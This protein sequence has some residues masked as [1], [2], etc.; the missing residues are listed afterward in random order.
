MDLRRRR[1]EWSELRCASAGHAE[2]ARPRH[3]GPRPV[4]AS[5]PRS[6]A[7]PR[8]RTSWRSPSR[9]RTSCWSASPTAGCCSASAGPL[10]ARLAHR[11]AERRAR[12]D[13]G[14]APARRP[15]D[16]RARRSL[17]RDGPRGGVGRA[18]GLHRRALGAAQHVDPAVQGR[19]GSARRLDRARQG[20]ARRAAAGRDHAVPPA[21]RSA[22]DV[23]GRPRPG[24]R[25]G[26]R[27]RG[28]GV[29]A[30]ILLGRGADHQPRGRRL[31]VDRDVRSRR[32]LGARATRLPARRG[33]GGRAP[34]A[35]QRTPPAGPR[36]ARRDAVSD[37]RTA[38]D[39][40]RVYG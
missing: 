33:R 3:E 34:R 36:A 27:L 6:G 35:L 31:R 32:P 30:G 7:R 19:R 37:S 13:L 5:R 22:T 2:H 11:R 29:P 10:P 20:A 26:L 40:D 18:A 8:S 14:P 15:G 16:A 23:A 28:A 38:V 25:P 24:R 39:S 12:R 17:R 21:A 1:R 9:R 4:H